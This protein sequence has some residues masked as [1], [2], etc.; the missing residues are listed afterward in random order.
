MFL[1]AKWQEKKH[2]SGCEQLYTY[3][4]GVLDLFKG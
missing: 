4:Q 2:D 1:K 3:T